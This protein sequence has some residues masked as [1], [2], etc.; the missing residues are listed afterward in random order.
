MGDPT[1]KQYQSFIG[2]PQNWNR[3]AYVL[4]NPLINTDPS[5]MECVWDD[6]SYDSEHDKDTGSVGQCQGQGGTWIELGQNDN[7]SGAAN[8]QLHNAVSN[9]QNGT[10]HSVAV[11]GIGGSYN[12]TTYNSNGTVSQTGTGGWITTYNHSSDPSAYPTISGTEYNPLAIASAYGQIVYGAAAQQDPEGNYQ[13]ALMQT[14]GFM[15]THPFG[16][17]LNESCAGYSEF[18]GYTLLALSLPATAEGL[19]AKAGYQSAAAAAAARAGTAAS[20]GAT[21][22]GYGGQICN[23]MFGK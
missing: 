21:A 11:M 18:E 17:D 6:G 7:W 4:N 20:V 14:I 23:A 22:L 1:S 2:N 3:Y 10:W 12:V 19:A 8:A 9:I 5:G 13:N 15:T 16:K